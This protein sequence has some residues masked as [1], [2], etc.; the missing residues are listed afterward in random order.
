[1][2]QFADSLPIDALL[3]RLHQ[4]LATGRSAVVT[5][6]P[7]AGKTTRLPLA[8]L[9]EPWLQGRRIVLLE[10]RRLAARAAARHMARL[11][12]EEIGQTV[13]YRTRLDT[14]VGPTTRIEVVTEGVLTRL[15]QVDPSLA[16]YGAVLFDEFHER[17]L[18]ADLG[19][20]LCLEARTL[21]REDLR[22]LVMSATL[23]CAAVAD[24]L[25]GAPVLA[26][27]GTTFPVETRYLDRSR[28]SPIEPLVAQTVRRVLA[29][30]RGSLLV[31][32]PGV[33]EIR[34][35]ERLLRDPALPDDVLLMPLYGDLPQEAQDQAIKP[36]PAG[37]RKVVL[38]TSL[39]ETSLT[40]EGVRLVIDSGLMR[41]PRF[42]PRSGLTKLAT[43]RVSRDAAE[44]R[45]GRAGRRGP[46]L[47]YRL[48]TEVEQRLLAE[49]RPPE[50]LDS[51]LAS[52]ALEL[53]L[54]GTDGPHRLRW[55]DPPPAGAFAQARALL[56]QLG[57]LD[58]A[59]RITAHGRRMA[60]LAMHP[61]LAH[62]V[63]KAVP[64]GAGGLACALAALLGE[65]DILKA[66]PRRPGADVRLRL[67]ILRSA[68]RPEPG[69]AV[70]HAAV[71][72]LRRTAEQWRRRLDLPP[73][74]ETVEA[75]GR[76]L[77][78]AYPDRIAQRQPGPEARFRLANGR[79]AWFPEPEPLA[80]EEFLVIADLDGAPDRARIFL[81][82][83]LR[84]EELAETCGDMIHT[85]D[86]VAWDE[87]AERVLARRQRR[88]GE[89]VLDDAVLPNPDPQ[90]V[91][92]SLLQ[93]I[94][95]RGLACLGWT[96]ALRTWQA[97]VQFL[98]R[99]EGPDAGWPDVSDAALL[100]TLERWLA[101]FVA[102]MTSL[103][104]VRRLDLTGPLQ[105][106]L[107]REQQQAL[108]RKAPTH[109]TVPS[110]SRLPLDYE[111]HDRPVLAVRVQ[112]LFGAR[113][114][115]RI[116]EGRMPVLIQLLSPARRPVQVTDD[117][118]GFWVK[119]YQEVRKALRGRYPKHAWPEDP[120]QAVPARG[121]TRARS[122][123]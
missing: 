106:L 90:A 57:A 56:R 109:L 89:L 113:E 37:H 49:R 120:L 1:M 108:D 112:E 58:E 114:T 31:F 19:L 11:L 83:P 107:T 123:V 41:V 52:L 81:A 8:L 46:G 99:V 36:A 15:L 55:L 73:S 7:G 10:P 84:R 53:A 77:A 18:Q 66:S 22:L 118:A 14:R 76:L 97:R 42:D 115:P 40:I 92:A 32:L 105:T 2:I 69:L 70:D 94:R 26:S 4:A 98:R 3:P 68:H 102:G 9:E 25:D 50:I 74:P 38:A 35:V 48:W 121:G 54:W 21:F 33:P 29:E 65:R 27:A 117:L 87:R 93:G 96:P 13:G 24:L 47:C 101:P 116:A 85:V 119:S 103:G 71:H 23:D 63:L 78:F 6:P 43:L 111:S 5:A 104:Q 64:L 17:S 28:S 75:A 62:M 59:G 82:A 16:G 45:R 44:Q 60:D 39:A 91:T 61:R 67:E 34:R 88:L 51:D 100:A 95:R 20:A 12:G 80:A 122:R 72:R 30:E 86:F 110:G 79:S